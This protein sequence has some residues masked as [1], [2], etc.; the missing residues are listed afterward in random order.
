MKAELLFPVFLLCST[1]FAQQGQYG[2][3]VFPNAPLGWQD[4]QIQTVSQDGSTITTVDGKTLTLKPESAYL[5]SAVSLWQLGQTIRYQCDPDCKVYNLNEMSK[6]Q[7]HNTFYPDRKDD[8]C[9]AKCESEKD[10]GANAA[11]FGMAVVGLIAQHHRNAKDKKFCSANPGSCVDN[12][13]CTFDPE[14]EQARQF[15]IEASKGG[16]D[17]WWPVWADALRISR[18]MSKVTCYRDP[19]GVPRRYSTLPTGFEQLY[20]R[21]AQQGAPLRY[22]M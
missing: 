12:H 17:S 7:I 5:Q 22:P 14:V 19:K 9:D 4:S 20:E 10:L 18:A 8:K 13:P 16:N 3:V 21:L 6:G 2:Q 11:L 15:A 1:A